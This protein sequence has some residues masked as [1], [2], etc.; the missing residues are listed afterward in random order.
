M[1]LEGK[2]GDHLRVRGTLIT[3]I[4]N[5]IYPVVVKKLKSTNINLTVVQE[6]K[7]GDH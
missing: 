3:C 2:L 7:S 5:F 4:P 6:E 1:A